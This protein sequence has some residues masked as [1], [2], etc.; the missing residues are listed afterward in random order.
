[1]P[2]AIA[3]TKRLCEN[4]AVLFQ[5]CL[6]FGMVVD[7]TQDRHRE[8]IN[9]VCGSNEDPVLVVIAPTKVLNDCFKDDVL[10]HANVSEFCFVDD[11][12]EGNRSLSV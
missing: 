5:I 11:S 6:E 4:K 8:D 1:M 10:V 2:A 12:M 9:A 3:M 7:P